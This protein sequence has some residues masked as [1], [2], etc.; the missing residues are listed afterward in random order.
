MV[1]KQQKAELRAY[2]QQQAALAIWRDRGLC[3]I[4]YFKHKRL[5]AFD[6]VHH[7]FGRGRKIDSWR[8]KFRNLMCVCRECHPQPASDPKATKHQDI[9]ELLEK[10]NREP[11]NIEFF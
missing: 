5:I 10:A 9:V 1:S 8:E 3:V 7:V 2:R 6:D 4:C 11:I